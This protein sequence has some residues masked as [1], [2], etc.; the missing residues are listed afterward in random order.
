[1]VLVG[2]GT[3]AVVQDSLFA[4]LVV[5]GILVED[6]GKQ[7]VELDTP[8]VGQDSLEL[9]LAWLVGDHNSWVHL[10]LGIQGWASAD[11]VAFPAFVA[12]QAPAVDSGCT[13]VCLSETLDQD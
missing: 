2:Q 11:L 9:L 5:L 7:V 6:L 1:V 12:V 4:V 13:C 8:A 3:A 10:D